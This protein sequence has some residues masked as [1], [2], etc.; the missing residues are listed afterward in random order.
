M[1]CSPLL[2][3]IID[4]QSSDIQSIARMARQARERDAGY[5]AKLETW[6]LATQAARDAGE[7]CQRYLRDAAERERVRREPGEVEHV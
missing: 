4:K 6:L 5:A 7:G 3:Q 2:Q 1:T